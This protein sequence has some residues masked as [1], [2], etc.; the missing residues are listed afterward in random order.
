MRRVCI[1]LVM[2]MLAAILSAAAASADP[3]TLYYQGYFNGTSTV[4]PGQGFVYHVDPNTIQTSYYWAFRPQPQNRGG[5][6]WGQ[7]GQQFQP[8]QPGDQNGNQGPAGPPQVILTP[9]QLPGIY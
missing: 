3:N 5:G 9:R 1:Y 7:P 6:D 4:V 8:G 2:A